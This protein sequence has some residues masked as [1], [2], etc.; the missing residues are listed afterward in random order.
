MACSYFL[1]RKVTCPRLSTGE[2]KFENGNQCPEFEQRD[3]IYLMGG[4][5]RLEWWEATACRFKLPGLSKKDLTLCVWIF[6]DIR[7]RCSATSLREFSGSTL[8]RDGWSW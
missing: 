5:L 6:T 3:D 2:V 4:R 1:S 8:K 7:L